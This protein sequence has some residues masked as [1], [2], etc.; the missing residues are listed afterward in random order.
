MKTFVKASLLLASTVG[1]TSG[2]GVSEQ[3]S[4]LKIRGGTEVSDNELSAVRT[5]TVAL[6]TSFTADGSGDSILSQGKSFCSGTI[7]GV[8]TIV[9][10]AHCI[11]ALEGRTTKGDNIFPNASDYLVHFGTK[12]SETGTYIV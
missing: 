7:I 8:R 4:D 6:T 12:V 1:M 10:A 5:S 2:C 3:E 9:T 11:Q